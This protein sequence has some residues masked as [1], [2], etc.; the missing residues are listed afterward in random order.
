MLGFVIRVALAL[1][2][3]CGMSFVYY[4][5]DINPYAQVPFSQFFSISEAS[6]FFI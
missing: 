5:P 1:A 4:N 6:M 2:L 3:T